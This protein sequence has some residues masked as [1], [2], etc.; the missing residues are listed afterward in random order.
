MA[1]NADGAATIES[2]IGRVEGQIESELRHMAT[3]ADVAEL[4]AQIRLL[5]WI[6]GVGMAANTAILLRLLFG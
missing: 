4:R 1:V 6:V 5:Q 3:K 2:R